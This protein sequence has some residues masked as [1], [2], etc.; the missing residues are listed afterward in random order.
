M[1]G[2]SPI[3]CADEIIEFVSLWDIGATGAH[4]K[5]A[6]VPGSGFA[7]I[8]RTAA[9]KYT[10]T[11]ARGLPI[12]PFLRLDVCHL[13]AVDTEQ[14]DSGARKSGFIAETAAAAATLKYES[15]DNDTA[16]QTDFVSGGQV[17]IRASFLKTR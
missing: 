8:A 4:T 13:P 10:I 15:W 5:A 7:S 1:S 12:G 17:S 6:N 11:F 2:Q 3:R 16:A 9:G 14:L